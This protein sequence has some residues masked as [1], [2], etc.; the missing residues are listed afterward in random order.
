MRFK[1]KKAKTI[2]FGVDRFFYFLNISA[3]IYIIGI[4]SEIK[5]FP[6]FEK[7]EK[8]DKLK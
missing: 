8:I 1:M 7:K 4:K 6:N 5:R 2:S 3:V